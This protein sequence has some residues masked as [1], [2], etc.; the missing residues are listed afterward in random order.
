MQKS[1]LVLID[2]EK[3][4][5][6]IMRKKKEPAKLPPGIDEKLV[7]KRL[8]EVK[9]Q[10]KLFSSKLNDTDKEET[11]REKLIMKIIKYQDNKRFGEYVRKKLSINYTRSQ[12]IKLN[13]KRL[14]Q[15]LNRIRINLNNR[16]VD[17]VFNNMA[18]TMSIGLEKSVT[19]FWNVDGFSD[20]LLMNPSFWEVF[21]KWKIE[22][23][24]PDI[25]PYLQL[26]YIITSTMLITHQMNMVNEDK[27]EMSDRMKEEKEGNRVNEQKESKRNE[28]V[29]S[30]G[31]KE[32]I[33][34]VTK[35]SQI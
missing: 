21:E 29:K 25:P 12:L 23:E 35:G 20:N 2:E 4:L 1:D 8:K 32:N 19:P 13:S 5:S 22:Q 16:N 3:V 34:A 30:A 28:K 11:E 18:K 14:E 7:I 9:T 26:S 31:R 24:L 17:V 27:R 10:K 33:R 6:K 15:L